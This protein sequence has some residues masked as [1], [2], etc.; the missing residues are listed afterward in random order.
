M[1]GGGQVGGSVAG[2]AMRSGSV[3]GQGSGLSLLSEIQ[4][5]S[6]QEA[7]NMKGQEAASQTLLCEPG[8]TKERKREQNQQPRRPVG[9]LLSTPGEELPSFTSEAPFTSEPWPSPFH[10]PNT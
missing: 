3:D 6:H 9:P 1:S 8:M 4:R 5:M 10:I 7:E 2:W